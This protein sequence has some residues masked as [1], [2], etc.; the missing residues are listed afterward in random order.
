M[1]IFSNPKK[2]IEKIVKKFVGSAKK[3]INKLAAAVKKSIKD[4]GSKV[5]LE[6]ENTGHD[7]EH[8]LREVGDEI[9]ESLHRSLQDLVE[10]AESGLLEAAL[11]K[12]LAI[13]DKEISHGDAPVVWKTEFFKMEIV[14]AK[15]VARVVQDAI[16]NGLPTSK[17]EWRQI[18][19]DLAPTV[20]EVTPGVPLVSSLGR[21]LNLEDIES[22]ALDK[23]L[24]EIGL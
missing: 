19:V 4:L 2:E 3:E 5:E 24:Q 16:D 13:V 17:S 7:I 21:K 9:Q 23:L 8:E 11:E 15:R 22:E 10:L 12:G 1:S 14:D 18:I 6:I 20:I